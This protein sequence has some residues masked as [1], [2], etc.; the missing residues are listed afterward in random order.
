MNLLNFY[1]KYREKKIKK[2][3]VEN[4]RRKINSTNK[5]YDNYIEVSDKKET[6][7]RI[8]DK[9]KMVDSKLKNKVYLTLQIF[10]ILE[11]LIIIQFSR[12]GFFNN[13]FIFII[14]FFFYCILFIIFIVKRRI[15]VAFLGV[16]ICIISM[17]GSSNQLFYN[18]KPV[19]KFTTEYKDF[20]VFK[21]LNNK[22]LKLVDNMKYLQD[23]NLFISTNLNNYNKLINE[24]NIMSIETS[25]LNI[26]NE[27]LENYKILITQ[28]ADL[29]IKNIEIIKNQSIIQDKKNLQIINANNLTLNDL[30]TQTSNIKSSIEKSYKVGNND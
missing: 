19:L 20:L 17:I 5:V 27:N 7:E 9:R 3:R 6:V 2:K 16:L 30:F 1:N 23:K 28:I 18:S 26:R 13:T 11:S 15:L 24:I 4:W 10:F 14:L 25:E 29:Q 22:N 8:F 21:N 12:Y